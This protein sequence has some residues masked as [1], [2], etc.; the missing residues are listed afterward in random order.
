MK[1]FTQHYNH[2]SF[3]NKFFKVDDT[4]IKSE[5]NLIFRDILINFLIENSLVSED[6]NNLENL[7][8]EILDKSVLDYEL[9]TGIN[10]LTR[11]LYNIDTQ[12]SYYEFLHFLKG[13]LDFDFYFQD[14]PTF[15]IHAPGVRNWNEAY[16]RWHTDC[17]FGHPPDELNIWITLTDN[18]HTG[19]YMMT[20]QDSANWFEEYDFDNERYSEN[21]FKYGNKKC[22]WNDR[23]FKSAY[24]VESK[25]DSIYLFDSLCIHTAIPMIDETRISI[26]IRINPVDEFV[27]G[28]IGTGNTGAE[29]WPGGYH[30]YHKNSIGE[31]K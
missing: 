19:F 2:R 6:F 9:D 12:D 28:Y 15:R 20:K 4:F 30:G 5:S 13:E 8:N 7:H 26:D 25:I 22:D 1:Q 24:E 16:P 21:V 31:F 18:E 14:T 27:D 3:F 23:G 17:N 11:L 29:F 10:E